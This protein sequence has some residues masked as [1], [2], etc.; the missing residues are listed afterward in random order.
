MQSVNLGRRN[1]KQQIQKSELILRVLLTDF[2][3]YKK[4]VH[5]I[6]PCQ[7]LPPDSRN[8][9]PARDAVGHLDKFRV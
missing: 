4:S 2:S 7:Q 9:P 8:K 6:H 3:N 1:F 5:P